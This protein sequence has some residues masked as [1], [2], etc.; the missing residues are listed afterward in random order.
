MLDRFWGKVAVAGED[1]CWLWTAAKSWGYGYISVGRGKRL[2]AHR[3]SYMIHN[4]VDIPDDLAVLHTCDVRACVNPRHLW[5]GT[6]AENS[7]DMCAK[8]RQ[9]YGER[10]GL[11]KLTEDD[12]REIR[13]RLSAGATA[14]RLGRE[15]GVD[16][17]TIRLIRDRVTWRHVA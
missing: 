9:A 6:N 14:Y 13:R 16:D 17:G 4:G 3:F 5:P 12:V 10:H 7:R 11:A 15:Y 1:E 2:R 8:G